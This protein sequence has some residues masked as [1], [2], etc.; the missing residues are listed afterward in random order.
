MHQ[1]FERFNGIREHSRP[2]TEIQNVAYHLI[3]NS[4]S[5]L[6]SQVEKLI[7]RLVHYFVFK[8][9]EHTILNLFWASGSPTLSQQ[10]VWEV[11]GIK[12]RL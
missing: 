8:Q 12:S 3:I 5:K 11:L 10:Q 1:I 2:C 7:S 4:G 6:Q 9:V